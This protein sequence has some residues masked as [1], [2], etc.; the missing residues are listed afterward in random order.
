MGSLRS[1]ALIGARLTVGSWSWSSL[2]AAVVR[3]DA[4]I[5]VEGPEELVDAFARLAHRF[6][7]TVAGRAAQ[8]RSQERP[9]ERS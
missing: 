5:E 6:S 2:A 4:D 7:R 1:S 3:F 9:Q 8:E